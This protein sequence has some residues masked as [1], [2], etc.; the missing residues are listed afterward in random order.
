M[1]FVLMKWGLFLAF[2]TGGEVKNDAHSELEIFDR[3]A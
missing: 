1:L 3:Q 2:D